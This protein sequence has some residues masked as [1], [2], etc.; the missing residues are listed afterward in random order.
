MAHGVTRRQFAITAG[1]ATLAFGS[2]AQAEAA[3]I[4]KTLRFISQ[5]DLLGLDPI[6]TTDYITRND[7]YIVFDTLFALDSKSQPDPQMGKLYPSFFTCGTP[8]ANYA[9][10]PAL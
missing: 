4:A 5:A 2:K 8:M 9:G 1:A 3:T 6:W 10:A 7:G